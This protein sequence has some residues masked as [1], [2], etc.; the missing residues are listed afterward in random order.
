M[1]SLI[2]LNGVVCKLASSLFR[3]RGKTSTRTVHS[4]GPQEL[5]EEE[6]HHWL[7]VRAMLYI[8]PLQE[9]GAVC[10]GGIE[11]VLLNFDELRE[12]AL[13]TMGIVFPS[14]AQLKIACGLQYAWI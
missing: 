5:A 2:I 9:R 7:S 10:L 12:G 11:C 14:V 8:N 6:N 1:M 3:A 4:I 13:N